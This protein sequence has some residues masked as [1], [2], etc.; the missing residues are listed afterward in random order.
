MTS[1]SSAEQEFL[2]GGLSQNFRLATESDSSIYVQK[3]F[4][5][6]AQGSAFVAHHRTGGTRAIVGVHA[7]AVKVVDVENQHVVNNNKLS[8]SSVGGAAASSGSSGARPDLLLLEE[9]NFLEVVFLPG[10]A[11]DRKTGKGSCALDAEQCARLLQRYATVGG[12]RGAATSTFSSTRTTNS[13]AIFA[14]RPRTSTSTTKTSDFSSSSSS[15]STSSSIALSSCLSTRA[16]T[17]LRDVL[18]RA[19]FRLKVS[20]I[21]EVQQAGS[22]VLDV[23]SA[24]ILAALEDF[25][26][27]LLG[28]QHEGGRS[29]VV[30]AHEQEKAMNTPMRVD[31]ME[32]EHREDHNHVGAVGAVATTD[33]IMKENDHDHDLHDLEER[34][35]MISFLPQQLH[36]AVTRARTVCI[37]NNLHDQEQQQTTTS[38][39]STRGIGVLT[40]PCIEEEAGGCCALFIDFANRETG[41]SIGV[42]G[43]VLPSTMSRIS[44]ESLL[45]AH[46][47]LAAPGPEKLQG[48]KEKLGEAKST[49]S[50]P[51]T[52]R[53][54]ASSVGGS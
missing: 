53:K 23:L 50:L 18:L 38:R 41:R 24:G 31:E 44:P 22:C 25:R 51:S 54:I 3:G 26:L 13:R 27:P 37:F 36:K 40:A 8:S 33:V 16:A 47:L 11:I 45:A 46:A 5:S 32:K 52:T 20:I 9:P 7:E 6:Q 14:T 29:R 19:G 34:N 4:L 35:R 28:I 15:C 10:A 39:T 12:K 21:A 2:R 42:H 1:Y 17:C 49:N 30:V 43:P 48:E